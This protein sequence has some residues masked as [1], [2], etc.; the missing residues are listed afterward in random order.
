MTSAKSVNADSQSSA[1]SGGSTQHDSPKASQSPNAS[2][3]AEVQPDTDVSPFNFDT[4]NNVFKFSPEIY[5]SDILDSKTSDK[6]Q[7]LVKKSKVN[8][9]KSHCFLVILKFYAADHK[10]HEVA[11]LQLLNKRCYDYFV[12][13]LMSQQKLKLEMSPCLLNFFE[14]D[15]QKQIIEK[16]ECGTKLRNGH[17][18]TLKFDQ[19]F[20]RNQDAVF[21]VENYLKTH[22]N[23]SKLYQWT[24]EHWQFLCNRYTRSTVFKFVS[25]NLSTKEGTFY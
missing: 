3:S 23:F 18:L 24:G 1:S 8:L 15:V 4:S 12:P 21:F 2:D 19:D 22:P 25:K 11:Q 14:A 7:A 20:P 9:A 17:V 16:K 6:S 13:Q 10:S 5:N